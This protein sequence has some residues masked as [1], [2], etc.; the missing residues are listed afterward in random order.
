MNSTRTLHI[1]PSKANCGV[2]FVSTM[3][4]HNNTINCLHNTH[5]RHPITRSLGRDM[6]CLLGVKVWFMFWCCHCN[7][8]CNIIL[9]WATLWRHPTV[10]LI[11]WYSIYYI[12]SVQWRL[13]RNFIFEKTV[14]V[15]WVIKIFY[16]TSLRKLT[17]S[18]CFR[19]VIICHHTCSFSARPLL[20]VA[21]FAVCRP[22]LWDLP[23]LRRH[24]ITAC[25]CKQGAPEYTPCLISRN[26]TDVMLHLLN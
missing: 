5:K 8:V 22:C 11:K 7:A 4:C 19:T 15:L 12:A 10:F 9:Y 21:M 17:Q 14:W 13:Y 6:G 23:P 20:A 24:S 25:M 18:I 2:S 1:S 26:G 3:W 16:W